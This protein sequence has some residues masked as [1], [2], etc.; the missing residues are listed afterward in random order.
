MNSVFS[1]RACVAA[2]AIA[3]MSLT[4]TA[5][6]QET[7][8]EKKAVASK[9]VARAVA[10][11]TKVRPLSVNIDLI[12]NTK[13]NGTLTDTSTLEMRTAFG[14]ANI[15]LSEVAGIRLASADNASTTVVMLNGDSITGATDIKLMT[16]ETE[17]GTATINGQNIASVLFVPGL[18]W[19]PQAGLN[20]KRWNLANTKTVKKPAPTTAKKS[21]VPGTRSSNGRVQYPSGTPQPAFR[22]R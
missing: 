17:W 20:G 5:Y 4:T 13:I 21:Q 15:P 3:A 9:P 7:K 1:L 22:G 8:D 2:A 14:I 6:A 11:P 18:T 12:S 19:N 16:V 10:S